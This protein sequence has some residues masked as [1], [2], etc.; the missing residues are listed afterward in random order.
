MGFDRYIATY[1]LAMVLNLIFLVINKRNILNFIAIII[2]LL[3]IKSSYDKN[4]Y[5]PE[6]NNIIKENAKII[7]ENVKKDDKVFIIDHKLDYGSEFVATKYL[8]SPIKTNLLYE[9]N[10][11]QFDNNIYYRLSQTKE[12]FKN[13]LIEG[14]YDYIFIIYVN[15]TFLEDYQELFTKDAIEKIKTVSNPWI[16]ERKDKLYNFYCNLRYFSSKM[17]K[18][19]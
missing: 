9:W 16:L 6:I 4:I 11:S 15:Y 7:T 10:I 14:K 2:Y 13:L 17:K 5:R 18:D 19:R 12:D 1:M 3:L 8:I